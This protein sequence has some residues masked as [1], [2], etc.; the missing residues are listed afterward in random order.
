MKKPFSVG[1]TI[2][3][4]L[5]LVREKGKPID[6]LVVVRCCGR[7]YRSDIKLSKANVVSWDESHTWTDLELSSDEWERS[8]IEFEVQAAN[9][10]WRNTTVGIVALQLSLIQKR[11]THQL[12]KS[13]PL[14]SPDGGDLH[15]SLRV[16]VFACGP[17]ESPPSPGEELEDTDDEDH[18]FLDDL[19][20]V[21]IDSSREPDILRMLVCYG[22][23]RLA[24]FR[25]R[26]PFVVCEFA[27]C[28]VRTAQARATCSYTF[29]ECFRIP[30]MT[31]VTEDTILIKIWDWNFM[32]AD[33]LLA[34]GRISFSELRT[35]HILPR[36]FNF[37]G[38]D[39]G[40]IPNFSE[41]IAESGKI[42]PCTYMGRL[43]LSAR[44]ER[45]SKDAE[46]LAAHSIAAAPFEEPRVTPILLFADVYE[47]QGAPGDKVYVEASLGPAK[48][49]T[50]WVASESLKRRERE[51]G[52]APSAVAAALEGAKGMANYF[53]GATPE[54]QDHFI[55]T[56]VDGRIPEL[57]LSV[58]EEEK[59]QWDVI[60]NV[61]AKGITK[62]LPHATRVAYQ[63]M[64]LAKVP[65]YMQNNPR[66]PTW[67]PLHPMP[68]LSGHRVP[69]AV[70]MTL[71]KA[72]TEA[73][74]RTKSVTCAGVTK[75]TEPC[76]ATSNPV[77]MECV[78]LELRLIQLH[79]FQRLLPSSPVYSTTA[80]GTGEVPSVAEPRWIK[81]K[82]GK[83][84]NKHRGDILVCFELIRKK[85]AEILPA[86]PMRPIVNMCK[87]SISCVNLRDLLLTPKGRP[88]DF[89]KL[90]KDEFEGLRRIRNPIVLI[91]VPSFGSVGRDRTVATIQYERNAG[92]DPSTPN[93]RW[94]NG[95][96]E[97]FDIFKA[98]S[99]D[100]DIPE[101]PI[102]DPTLTIQVYDRKAK[103]KYFIGQYTLHLIPL[104]PW[105]TDVPTAL[106]DIQPAKDYEDSI[107]LKKIGGIM[108]GSKAKNKKEFST[109]NVVLDAVSTADRETA[110]ANQSR[111]LHHV[112][113]LKHEQAAEGVS[114]LWL[115]PDSLPK[116]LVQSYALPS[117]RPVLLVTS[118]FTLNVFIPA[119]FVLCAEGKRAAEKKTK[120]QFQ[121]PS[122]ESTVENYLADVDFA[123]DPLKKRA[124]GE[125]QHTGSVKFFVNLTHNEEPSMHVDQTVV[126]WALNESR[127]RR[128]F[129]GEEAYPKTLKIRVYVIRAINVHLLKGMTVANP[130]LV[131]SVGKTKM[132]FRAENKP[133]SLNPDFFT[134]WERDISFPEES[135]L[136]ISV[137][138]AHEKLMQQV[139]DVFLG[140]T[141][142][143]LEERWFS[144]EW[145]GFM[146]K[147]EVP[148]EYRPLRRRPNGGI[149]GSLE[150]WVEMMDSQKAGKVPRFNLQKPS[151][152]DIEIRVVLWGCRGL[153]FKHLGS[154]KESVDAILR[155]TLDCT[156]YHGPQQLQQSTDVH[157]YSKTG[158]AVFNWRVV[159]SGVAAPVNSCII[160]ISAYDFRNIG[161]LPFIGEVLF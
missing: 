127:L 37:Y 132:P 86:Y 70:L 72:K 113:V 144:K 151:A 61:Y 97:S 160:Q 133:T 137:W 106:E 89:E 50:R 26:D 38:F 2:H 30:V 45:L 71:E 100:V 139:D 111:Y 31:P 91:S 75:E 83:R 118:M 147:N 64:P 109:M 23:I 101:D 46:L 125:T 1:F 22:L 110:E 150:M 92:G 53:L 14:Q 115:N 56:P 69:S 51:L 80:L 43:L 16:T 93:R 6:P 146:H 79:D 123:P 135:R 11:K 124:M 134:M 9:A 73:A 15:G 24:G 82:G 52:D 154:S 66:A 131:F 29:N 68:H 117:D 120:E 155:C 8:F 18:G 126:P 81:L 7:E 12:K 78:Q 152:T 95:P 48:E 27:G 99:L 96:Y 84:M 158:A 49:R 145:Q 102:F 129:R 156:R 76:E 148:M 94:S 140:S 65:I 138:S 20:N 98:V 136:E 114:S 107:D 35:R 55:F 44:A 161:E 77:F 108:R 121:R 19:R 42:T 10:F 62:N 122:V 159:Y 4:A 67:V 17:G 104:I 33:E 58:P 141:V 21:V 128:H 130:Y 103:P 157:Y 40:E 5:N 153:H 34:V 87:L 59:Q 41:I 143:D 149:T 74:A 142:I 105:V 36:W 90:V 57:R 60:I 13:L 39:V 25:L 47:V 116:I 28:R 112:G 32:S 54:G 88:I 85:D 119:K 3:E 63:R